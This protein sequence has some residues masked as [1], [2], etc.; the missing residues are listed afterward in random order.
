VELQD[1]ELLRLIA[2]GHREAL[3]QLYRRHHD[4][5]FRF[6]LHMGGS[7]SVAEDIVQDT[8]LAVARAARRYRGGEARFSTYLYGIVRNLTR[9]R[10]RREMRLAGVIELLKHYLQPHAPLAPEALVERETQTST[11]GRVRRAVSSLPPRYREVVVLCDLHGKDYAEVA[12]IIGRPIGT[13]RSRLF[14]ARSL[15][16]DKLGQPEGSL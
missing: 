4:M 14:R 9:R 15:L 11:V 10:H 1:D 6:A 8:F 2:D 16:A 5:V 12:A 7:E 3:A 13:V